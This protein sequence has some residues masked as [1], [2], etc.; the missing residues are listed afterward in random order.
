MKGKYWRLSEKDK[1]E[2]RVNKIKIGDRTYDVLG[3]HY[4]PSKNPKRIGKTDKKRLVIKNIVPEGGDPV[5]HHGNIITIDW[6][7]QSLGTPMEEVSYWINESR[8][9][10][11]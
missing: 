1:D 3:Y 11:I 4:T 2:L 6:P 7:Y 9:S 5:I 10:L 8:Q